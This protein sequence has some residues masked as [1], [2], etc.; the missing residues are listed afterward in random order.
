MI[1]RRAQL[2]NVFRE[3]KE[4]ERVTI[5]FERE[6][7]IRFTAVGADGLPVA[8][9]ASAKRLSDW[10]FNHDAIEVCHS[11]HLGESDDEP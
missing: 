6:G 11:Y 2:V 3:P 8:S 7:P 10:L 1:P 5:R 9:C 4:S